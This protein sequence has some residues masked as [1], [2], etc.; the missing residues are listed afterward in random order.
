[1]V[2]AES[3]GAKSPWRIY[4]LNGNYATFLSD[5]GSFGGSTSPYY[6]GLEKLE[7]W[8]GGGKYAALVDRKHTIVDYYSQLNQTDEIDADRKKE[9]GEVMAKCIEKFQEKMGWPSSSGFTLRVSIDDIEVTKV[10][11][12]CLNNMGGQCAVVIYSN[13]CKS[14]SDCGGGVVKCVDGACTMNA[15]ALSVAI[16]VVLALVAVIM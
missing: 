14:G 15:V 6:C 2:T 13:A 4:E 5:T 3:G 12:S 9:M 8:Q 1:M 10:P 16:A 11:D 7:I